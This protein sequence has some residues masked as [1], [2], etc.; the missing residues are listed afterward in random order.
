MFTVIINVL[1]TYFLGIQIDRTLMIKTCGDNDCVCKGYPDPNT[2]EALVRRP[3]TLQE[4][5]AQCILH[6]FCFGIEYWG[7]QMTDGNPMNPDDYPNCFQCPVN[8]G[9]RRTVHA[10]DVS[11]MSKRGKGQWADVYV[12]ERKDRPNTDFGNT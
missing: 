8:P 4:C 9:K 2:R 7:I 3:V 1:Y 11:R 10:I 6:W 12:K 5:A